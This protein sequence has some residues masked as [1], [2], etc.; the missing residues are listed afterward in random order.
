MKSPD[1]IP[2]GFL[3]T[4]LLVVTFATFVVGCTGDDTSTN[5]PFVETPDTLVTIHILYTNDEH[6]WMKGEFEDEIQYGNAAE[7]TGQ[8]NNLKDSYGDDPVLILS[9]GDMWTGPAISTWFKG[10][11]MVEIMN[12]MG[13]MAAAAGNH[14][15]D[16]TLDTL[17]QRVS[18]MNFPILGANV[19]DRT[20]ND[21]F[22]YIQP[23]TLIELGESDELTV[24]IIGLTTQTTV[25]STFPGNVVDVEF[26]DY[27][28]TIE[29]YAPLVW[30]EGAE[31]VIIV[32][33]IEEWE[34]I[35]LFPVAL[36]Y[37]IKFIGGGHTHEFFNSTIDGIN[38]AMSEGNL[39]G[40]TNVE[41]TYNYIDSTTQIVL[42]EYIENLG[43]TAD[44][45]VES[46]LD[47]WIEM[48]HV[49]LNN[50]LGYT[51]HGLENRSPGLFN[52][53][54]D[55][56]LNRFP[57]SDVAI[58]NNGGIRQ[59]M[60]Q[61]E[62]SLGEIVG[63]LPFDNF[64]YEVEISGRDLMRYDDLTRWAVGGM[65]ALNGEYLF[66]N[67]DPIH[68]DSIYNLMITDYMYLA[69]ANF[70]ID[71]TQIDPEPHATGFHWRDP[72]IEYI[73]GFNTSVSDPLENY[74]DMNPRR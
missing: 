1:K 52:L 13:Y 40:F 53:I 67:G 21:H 34:M 55:S 36:E 57:T 60:S 5:P 11:S 2:F 10:R 24:G 6:G 3:I 70:E 50:I 31:I 72:L 26:R 12:S 29:E 8:W 54:P 59:G 65:T 4:H 38:F 7:L 45:D 44:P 33:H 20:T 15:F 66:M 35:S 62:I 43:G 22:S 17:E 16:F 32:G 37:G 63:I 49:E 73:E 46:I 27:I 47:F 74:I 58:T 25:W 64:L 39:K 18:E 68:P 69:S 9:G 71:F 51:E 56:W 48:E 42:S 61:G 28:P 23:Y 30:A 14:E 19:Y 41:F